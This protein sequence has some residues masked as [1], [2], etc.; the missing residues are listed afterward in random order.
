M[1]LQQ[2]AGRRCFGRGPPR[3]ERSTEH[4]RP[5]KPKATAPTSHARG[6]L[7]S[8][9][10]GSIVSF[11]AELFG[12]A[13]P[14]RRTPSVRACWLDRRVSFLSPRI[15]SSPFARPRPAPV[16][17]SVV[18]AGY[19]RRWRK[20]TAELSRHAPHRTGRGF[21]TRLE[22]APR[23]SRTNGRRQ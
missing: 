23:I 11:F 13:L 14:L 19:L 21:A 3:A 7:Y 10:D 9:G 18:A 8:G 2:H 12:S 16:P 17:G 6:C 15:S 1:L 4:A 22:H 5:G 20:P